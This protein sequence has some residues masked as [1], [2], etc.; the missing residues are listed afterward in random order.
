MKPILLVGCVLMGML[1]IPAWSQPTARASNMDLVGYNDLQARS[2]YQPV[3][4]KQGARWIAY[5]GHPGGA[6]TA[7]ITAAS[8]SILLPAKWNRTGLR[9]STSPI[10]GVPCIWRTF[11]ENQRIAR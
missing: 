4:Q 5:I 6:H 9:S 11:R 7:A 10:L 1:T 3:I 8:S 2:A